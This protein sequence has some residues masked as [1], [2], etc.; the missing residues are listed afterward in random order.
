MVHSGASSSASTVGTRDAAGL[1]DPKGDAVGDCVAPVGSRDA[2]GL[3]DPKGDD[4]AGLADP[5]GDCVGDFVSGTDGRDASV[6]THWPLGA[7]AHL[8]D[9]RG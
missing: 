6:G 4:A 9:G 8:V 2:A 3:A 1:A 5:K 7:L